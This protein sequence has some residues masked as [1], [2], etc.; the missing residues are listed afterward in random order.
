MEAMTPEQPVKVYIS[1]AF[2]SWGDAAHKA[3]PPTPANTGKPR[4]L[5]ASSEAI[6]EGVAE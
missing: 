5:R 1:A 2:F 3:L 4:R 6:I